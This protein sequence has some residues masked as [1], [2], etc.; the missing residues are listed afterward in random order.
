M[1]QEKS[2]RESVTT[3]CPANWFGSRCQYKCHCRGNNCTSEGLCPLG[4]HEE[5][6]GPECQYINVADGISEADDQGCNRVETIHSK[7]EVPFRLQTNF[8]WMRLRFKENI[9]TVNFKLLTTNDIWTPCSSSDILQIDDVTLDIF[10]QDTTNRSISK[11]VFIEVTAAVTLCSIYVSG[12]RNVALKASTEQS[13]IFSNETY[14]ESFARS[15]NS[16][17]G[18]TSLEFKDKSCSRTKESKRARYEITFEELHT[19]HAYRLYAS[20]C[21]FLTA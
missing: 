3:I 15:E 7:L 4:C 19:I 16:V 14:D 18:N 17:D 6:F 8:T 9:K 20:F 13:L 1:Q 21:K 10:C 2:Q 12:G 5:W 11:S